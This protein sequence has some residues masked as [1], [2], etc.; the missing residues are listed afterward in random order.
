MMSSNCG[1]LLARASDN[2]SGWRRCV[3]TCI[4]RISFGELSMPMSWGKQ[5]Q[6]SCA[7]DSRLERREVSQLTQVQHHI[8]ESMPAIV[9]R[10]TILDLHPCFLPA[11]GELSW[12]S[13]VMKKRDW[14][15]HASGSA[16]ASYITGSI[17][18]LK[19]KGFPSI[20]T[21]KRF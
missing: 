13:N 18:S 9:P 6:Q 5:T 1:Y 7:A 15:Y 3:C 11:P 4:D 19:C 2:M 21:F 17:G 16:M 14:M 10:R 8:C 12:R 20:R